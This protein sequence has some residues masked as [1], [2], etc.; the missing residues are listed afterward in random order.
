[1]PTPARTCQLV[2]GWHAEVEANAFL[3][4]P[5][6]SAVLYALGALCLKRALGFGIGPW[7]VTFVSNLVLGIL[8]L[9]MFLI[10]G[11]EWGA[12]GWYWPLVAAGT[13][14]IGQVF[15]FLA[16]NVGDVSVA[17]PL[18]GIK[19]VLVAFFSVL[20][21]TEP[22]PGAWWG[23]AVL[24]AVAVF[25]LSGRGRIERRRLLP[26][27]LFALSA[28]ASFAL[29]DVLVQKYTP[30]WGAGAFLPTMFLAVAVGSVVFVPFFSG[31]IG[32]LVR[33]AGVWIWAGAG[34][35]AVQ[36]LGMALALGL[37][38][39]ATAVNVVYGTRG[40]W[41]IVLVW[42][43]GHWFANEERRAGGAAMGRRLLGAVLMVAAVALVL[44]P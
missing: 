40:L 37:F 18:L 25:L 13:F 1:M 33:G 24:C 30:L 14:I 19:V 4:L 9:P 22:V 42:F 17:T 5:L 31:S 21:L 32:G 16:L 44:A 43:V 6:G 20:V 7:R 26:S 2:S 27:V 38:G 3:L 35:M 11:V 8:F 34:L 39:S 36:A 15:T 12:G 41:S 10:G 29:T 23:G 28:A